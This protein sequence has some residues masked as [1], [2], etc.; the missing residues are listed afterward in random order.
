MSILRGKCGS[1][2]QKW[3]VLDEL[4][5]VRRVRGLSEE[6]GETNMGEDGGCG[7]FYKKWSKTQVGKE[8]R[9]I[10]VHHYTE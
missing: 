8:A 5:R 9:W 3:S 7:V 6:K 10:L 4:G 2:G 1:Q